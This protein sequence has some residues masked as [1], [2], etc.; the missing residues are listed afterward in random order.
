[1]VR[2]ARALPVAIVVD[3]QRQ[4][5][6][7][8]RGRHLLCAALL[9]WAGSVAAAEPSGEA[10]LLTVETVEAA[11]E[12]ED[13]ARWLER[14]FDLDP[15]QSEALVVLPEAE[16]ADLDDRELRLLLAALLPGDDSERV[17]LASKR[18]SAGGGATLPLATDRPTSGELFGGVRFEL[19]RLVASGERLEVATAPIAGEQVLTRA[20]LEAAEPPGAGR[21]ARVRI[22]TRGTAFESCNF[23]GLIKPRHCL[24][25][26]ETDPAAI[27]AT[28]G[29]QDLRWRVRLP[30]P[31]PFRGLLR[32]QS[33]GWVP[34]TAR[35]PR[36]E[37]IVIAGLAAGGLLAPRLEQVVLHGN[38][39]RPAELV[40]QRRG[41]ELTSR[42]RRIELRFDG[43]GRLAE[44]ELGRDA[45]V[46]GRPL[47]EQPAR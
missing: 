16:L 7:G 22:D 43:A 41:Q 19:E 3:V 2:I 4:T 45:E 24:I 21:A 36:V 46:E 12:R 26:L 32:G 23:R 40:T 13:G 35:A 39:E 44:I 14:T 18:L 34:V 17:R 30:D 28:D 25:E 38:D 8:T 33:D 27:T 31:D 29:T 42:S 37:A 9:A 47:L 6:S 15:I 20:L 1:V 11:Q 5:C 10:E